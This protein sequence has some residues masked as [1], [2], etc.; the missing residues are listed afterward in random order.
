MIASNTVSIWAPQ[1]NSK[2]R[3]RLD[4]VD[5]VAIDEPDR[6]LLGQLEPEAQARRVDPPVADPAQ[7]P[8][9]L[10]WR[11]GVCDPGQVCGVGD[12]GKAVSLLPERDASRCGR[13]RRRT[14]G[15]S[16]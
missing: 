2:L 9:S 13:D 14:R 4:L 11:Q 8:Y 6:A 12:L 5:R 16:R 7:A 3:L 1:P 10:G 15:R